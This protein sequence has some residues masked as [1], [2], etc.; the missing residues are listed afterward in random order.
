MKETSEGMSYLGVKREKVE[1]KM[2]KS[3]VESLQERRGSDK[4]DS[5]KRLGERGRKP[6]LM[7]RVSPIMSFWEQPCLIPY[8]LIFCFMIAL[9]LSPFRRMN[10]RETL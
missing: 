7:P 9:N 2:Q 5:L 4:E 1:E 8:L 6:K 10:D 3:D